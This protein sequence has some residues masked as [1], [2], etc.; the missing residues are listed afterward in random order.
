MSQTP[1]TTPE[2]SVSETLKTSASETLEDGVLLSVRGLEKTFRL[3]AVGGRTVRGLVG[4][5]L[6]VYEGEHLAL[7]GRSGAGKSSLIK[8]VHRTYVADAG[9]ILYRTNTTAHNAD[10]GTVTTG[11]A[12][13]CHH[14]EIV[15]L[16]AMSDHSVAELRSREIGYVS[17]FLRAAPRRRV[18]DVVAMQA[19]RV[20]VD[21]ETADDM[22][23]EV[24]NRVNIGSELFPTFPS[25]L[26]G[27]EKQRVNLAAGIVVAPRLLL[28]DEPVSALDPANREAVLSVIKELKNRG[29][30]VLSIFHDVDAMHQIATR[31]ALMSNGALETVGE[32]AHVLELLAQQSAKAQAHESVEPQAVPT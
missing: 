28:L 17:Q 31:V 19:R 5:D 1:E 20:G 26:S 12:P 3:H 9:Q 22:A 27:G 29:S 14:G 8:C 4:V 13:E 23:A 24:L 11:I 32:P 16:V 7:A 2:T 25:L 21:A 18:L 6:D 15:D 10:T 30:T